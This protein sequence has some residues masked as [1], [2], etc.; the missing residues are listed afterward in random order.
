MGERCSECKQKVPMSDEQTKVCYDCQ[1][2][3]YRDHKW[4]YKKVYVTGLGEYK[5]RYATV[6]V[7]KHCDYPS[8]YRPPKSERCSFCCGTG[9]KMALKCEMCNGTGR[10]Q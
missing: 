1:Q 4:R 7:H 2:P 5:G 3:I 9:K 10:E 8:L 6:M